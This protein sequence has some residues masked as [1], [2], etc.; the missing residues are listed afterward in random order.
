SPRRR[1]LLDQVGIAHSVLRVDVDES[2]RGAEPA[3]D[4]VQRLAREKAEA[5]WR[6]VVADALPPLPVLGAD[7]AGGVDERILGKPVDAADAR[8]MLR[9]LSGRVHEVLTGV[10]LC[11]T[12]GSR[13]ALSR[14]R[15]R[16]RVLS[17]ADIAAYWASGE[18][19]DKAGAYGIQGL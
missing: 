2:P 5:G 18:P 3:A 15:V 8:A 7:T 4:Y 1:E 17:D 13:L 12:G 16:F 14:T 11:G 10:A 19:A 9:L 6:R